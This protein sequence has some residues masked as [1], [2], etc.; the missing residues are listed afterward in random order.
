MRLTRL[1]TKQPVGCDTELY[2]TGQ[3]LQ[4]WYGGGGFG[5]IVGMGWMAGSRCACVIPIVGSRLL[6]GDYGCFRSTSGCRH[7]CR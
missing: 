4:C 2:C 7:H 1:P 6:A 5:V 3:W